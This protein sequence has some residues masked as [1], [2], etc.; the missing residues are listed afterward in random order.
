MD[1]E[2]MEFSEIKESTSEQ[3]PNHMAVASQVLGII[4]AA[5]FCCCGLSI[6]LGG[7]GIVFALLSKVEDHLDKKA[8]IGLICSIIGVLLGILCIFAGII[9]VM[10]QEGYL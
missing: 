2:T 7:L 9:L 5:T 6:A 4:S 10:I 8:R 3:R 1:Y